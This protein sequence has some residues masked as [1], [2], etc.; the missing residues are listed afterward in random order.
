MLAL[1]HHVIVQIAA[2][3]VGKPNFKLY[4]V[5]GDDV[6]IADQ[7]VAKSYHYIMSDVLG[8]GINLSKSLISVHSFEFAKQTFHKGINVSPIGPKNLLVAMKSVGGISS[9]FLDMV[10]KGVH[11]NAEYLNSMFSGRVPTL[12]ERARDLVK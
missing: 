11:L 8:V 7:S 12:N 1:T 6:V 9:V 10:N 2:A 3:R 4:A 5:L